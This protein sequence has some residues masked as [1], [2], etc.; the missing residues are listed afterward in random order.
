VDC[1]GPNNLPRPMAINPIRA[2]MITNEAIAAYWRS[3][4]TPL[5]KFVWSIGAK[6]YHM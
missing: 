2:V 1:F 4:A 5:S 6:V 3:M